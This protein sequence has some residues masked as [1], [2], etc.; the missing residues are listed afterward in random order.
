M[1]SL[2]A[3]P[4]PKVKKE[5]MPPEPF[6]P[7]PPSNPSLV[8]ILAMLRDKFTDPH[9]IAKRHPEYLAVLQE[10]A[11]DEEKP[12]LTE[13]RSN[14]SL[15]LTDDLRAHV[16]VMELKRLNLRLVPIG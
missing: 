4:K 11:P 13:L 7:Q 3:F 8:D 12:V 1:L 15:L 5:E 16:L 14:S 9:E 6:E 2:A 10:D